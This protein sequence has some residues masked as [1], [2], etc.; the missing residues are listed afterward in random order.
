MLT[1]PLC[2]SVLPYPPFKLPPEVV[3]AIRRRIEDTLRKSDDTVILQ[4]ANLLKVS[5]DPPRR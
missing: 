4:V 1:C 3:K 2:K 5:L